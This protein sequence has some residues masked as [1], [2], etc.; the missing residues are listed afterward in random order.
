MSAT[1]KLQGRFFK[2]FKLFR[3]KKYGEAYPG[4]DNP[5]LDN[6]LIDKMLPSEIKA[7]LQQHDQMLKEIEQYLEKKDD[8]NN[9]KA[10]TLSDLHTVGEE[11][12]DSDDD[13]MN[14]S[15][16]IHNKKEYQDHLM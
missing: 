8:L 16:F 1:R 14:P 9:S 10:M 4:N 3:F 5:N 6:D 2:V 12:D 15:A 7:S 11:D 13:E